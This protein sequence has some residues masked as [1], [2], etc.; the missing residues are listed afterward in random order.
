MAAAMAKVGLRFE[1]PQAEERAQIVRPAP[2]SD[3]EKPPILR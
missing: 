3:P 2:G 1:L